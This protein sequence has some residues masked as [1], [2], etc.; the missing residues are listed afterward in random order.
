MPED[1]DTRRE[2]QD[3]RRRASEDDLR[4]A[5]NQTLSRLASREPGV[6]RDGHDLLVS[7]LDAGVVRALGEDADLRR[8]TAAL[9]VLEA[10]IVE[11]A[12]SS[13]PQ[14]LFD[15][16]PTDTSGPERVPGIDKQDILETLS[17]ICPLWPFC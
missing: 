10:E 1:Q 6:D 15:A 11:T 5:M 4:T 17:R 8:V 16:G 2:G 12:R 13:G 9:D 14:T 7:L 3:T